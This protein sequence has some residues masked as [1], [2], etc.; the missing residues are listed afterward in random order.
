MRCLRCLLLVLAVQWLLSAQADISHFMTRVIWG[1]DT[2]IISDVVRNTGVFYSSGTSPVLSGFIFTHWTISTKQPFSS[3]DE[4]GVSR[5]VVT[6][7]LYE[8]TILTANYISDAIDED[9]DGIPDGYELYWY[10][11]LSKDAESDTDGDGF[12][13]AEEIANGTNPLTAEYENGDIV[14]YCDGEVLTYNPN[15]YK[16]VSVRS[17][18]DGSLLEASSVCLRPATWFETVEFSPETSAFAYWIC[19]G[20]EVRDEWG[21]AIDK[22]SFMMSTNDVNLV[23]VAVDD[24]ETR[25]KLYWYGTVDI[26]MDS[27]TDGDGFIF[28]EELANGTNPLQ[29]DW[30]VSGPVGF[31][32]SLLLQ[33][34]PNGYAKYRIQSNP[35]G[36]LFET[37]ENYIAPGLFVTSDTLSWSNSVFAC[38]S[39]NGVEQRDGWGRAID[40]VTFQMPRTPVTLVANAIENDVDRIKYY[41]YGTTD[42]SMDSDTDGDGFTFA[43]ELVN[44]TDPIIAEEIVQGPIVYA[45]TSAFEMNLQPFEQM[46]GAIVGGEYS[47]AFTS[48]FAGNGAISRTFGTDLIPIVG[49]LNNDGLFDI[50]LVHKDGMVLLVNVGTK[51]NPEFEE[52]KEVSTNGVDIVYGELSM[53]DGL[54][55]DT[56]LMDCLGCTLGDV[57]QDGFIDILVSDTEGRIW[58]YRNVGA[59]NLLSESSFTLQHKVW[60]GSFAGFAEG[61][62]IA[63][64]DWE[65]D[66]D[67]DCLAGTADGKL[68]LLR[69]PRV[70][71]PTNLKAMAGVDTV[72]LT[73]DPNQQSRIRG[74]RLYRAEGNG[75]EFARIAEPQLPTYRDAPPEITTY[76][77]KVS[78]VSRFY[79]SGNSTPIVAES[80]ATEVL[81]ATLGGV[82]FGWHDVNAKLGGRVEVVI[83]IENA[84]NY[85]VAGKSQS[86]A[87]DPEYLRPVE[88]VKSGITENVEMTDSVQNGSWTVTMTS[89][90]LPAGSGRF[91]TFVF[92]ALKEGTTTVGNAAVE[93][94]AAPRYFLGDVNGDGELTKADAKLLA[95]LKN[96]N[97]KWNAD[98]LKAGD[99]NGNGKLDNADYQAVR[100]LLRDLGVL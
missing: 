77:Y 34:N 31:A 7:K 91:L 62:R 48:P 96:G 89:G 57:D 92:D 29:A 4:W 27:D 73:W 64:V 81:R 20:K 25:M 38:W 2:N 61:L 49:D 86:L 69:D 14:R 32:D 75:E 83:S 55:L 47:E 54:R 82:T 6:F 95:R 23:A 93:I 12:T 100:A 51:S 40:A 42:I 19:N 41:W 63:A 53:L 18:P 17:E 22:I 26:A 85:N 52:R 16:W 58:F 60:G 88:V 56:P 68:M 80:P 97:G 45:D 65:G 33:Y 3:R 15:G 24:Y 90:V 70:G 11:D 59:T 30:E 94:S 78:S 72:V 28:A 44:G 74:Y 10:G 8:D 9:V 67:L 36:L 71:R 84:L 5:D 35:E 66:G 50:I 43:E 21:R 87:Y 1:S 99:F 39:L 98:E 79:T 46:R 13:F 37:V 76:G